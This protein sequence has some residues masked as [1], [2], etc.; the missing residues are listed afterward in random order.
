M[1]L[2]KL[3]ILGIC[4]VL[5]LALMISGC[6]QEPDLTV[7]SKEF[8]ESHLL[9]HMMAS[10][11]EENTD[12]TV[13][14][15]VGLG[16]TEV[17]HQ[18]LLRGD[19]DLYAEY[20]GTGLM[21]ILGEDPMDDPDEVYEFVSQKYADEMELKWLEPFGFNN[22]YTLAVRQEMADEMNLRT[23]SDLIPVSDELTIGAT[24]EFLERDDGYGGLRVTYEGMEFGDTADLDPGLMYMAV[25]N[26]DVDVI[27]AFATDGRIPAFDLAVLEDDKGFFPPYYAAPVIRM[28]TLE[29]YPELEDV[30]N[31]LAG[32]VDDDTM[33]ELNYK[34]DEDGE[35][36]IVVAEDFLR[37]N[38]LIE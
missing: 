7:G 12:L 34:V 3:S 32:L 5:G 8:T 24:H 18:A 26:E 23:F 30:L 15:T 13:E 38:G 19:I 1:I 22:T 6:G 33:A 28:E 35:R 21:A 36:E 27:S 10:L 4:L 20:T 29:D 16:G 2:K 9:A 31:Q 37:E 14:R 25:A 17:N 11:I